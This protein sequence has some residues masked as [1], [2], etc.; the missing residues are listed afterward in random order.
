[1]VHTGLE[2]RPGV[3]C[4]GVAIDGFWLPTACGACLISGL[5]NQCASGPGSKSSI[6]PVTR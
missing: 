6:R 3:T 5:E 1:M 2:W 4:D